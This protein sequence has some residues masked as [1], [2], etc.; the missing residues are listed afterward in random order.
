MLLNYKLALSPIVRESPI[1]ILQKALS[2]VGLTVPACGALDNSQAMKQEV[3]GV[4][5]EAP[6]ESASLTAECHYPTG[7]CFQENSCRSSCQ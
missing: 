5:L 6:V 2:A 3:L 1:N 7:L 4:T